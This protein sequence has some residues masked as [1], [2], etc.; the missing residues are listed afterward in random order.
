MLAFVAATFEML[1]S[2]FSLTLD[3]NQALFTPLNKQLSVANKKI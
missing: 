3:Q 1:F 2:K